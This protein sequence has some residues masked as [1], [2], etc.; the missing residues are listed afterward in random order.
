MSKHRTVIFVHGCFWHGHKGCKRATRP[1]TNTDFWNDKIEANIKRDE[2]VKKRLLEMGWR[3]L[4][5]WQCQ[6]KPM[7]RLSSILVSLM[8][9]RS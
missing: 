8:E 3:V 4:V 7:D 6:I 2:V 1:V 5:I 9:E